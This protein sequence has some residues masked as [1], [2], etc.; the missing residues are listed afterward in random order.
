MAMVW[1]DMEFAAIAK[2]NCTAVMIWKRKA[3]TCGLAA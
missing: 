3:Q 2:K 1:S